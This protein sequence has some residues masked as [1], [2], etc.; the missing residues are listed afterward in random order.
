MMNQNSKSNNQLAAMATASSHG[1]SISIIAKWFC[2][3][4]CLAMGQQ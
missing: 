3:S 1:I 2:D 4:S